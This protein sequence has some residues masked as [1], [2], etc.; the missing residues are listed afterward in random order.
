VPLV[1][2]V[3]SSARGGNDVGFSVSFP[4]PERS[5]SPANG[6]YQPQRVVSPSCL[7]VRPTVISVREVGGQLGPVGRRWL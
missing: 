3:A 5:G 4:E 6:M 2:V 7:D 1:L